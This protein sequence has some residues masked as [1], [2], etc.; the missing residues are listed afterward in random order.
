M[1]ILNDEVY[2]GERKFKLTIRDPIN[3]EIG[4]GS[5]QATILDDEPQPLI[6]HFT[7]MPS[8]NHGETSFTFNISFN[9]D[10]A[11]QYLVMQNDA[12]TVTNGEITRA[13]RIDGSRDFWRITVQP[14]GGADVTVLLPATVSCSDT[15][16]ICT[17]DSHA[18]PLSN[19]VTHTFPGTQ[20][21]AKFTGLD[22]YHDGSTPF[23]FTLG[24][25]EEVDTTA[26][27][28]RDHAL[29]ITGGT[30]KTV[31]QKD[32][33]STRRWEV[34]VKPAGVDDI[35]VSI[36]GAIDCATDGHI[37]TSE[38]ELL[39]QAVTQYS[40]GPELISVS[41]ATVREADG[42]ELVFT[43]SIPEVWFG[44]DIT[45]DYATSHGTATA[46]DYTPTSGTLD[47]RWH[48]SLIVTVPV[49]TDTIT[50][51]A[52][53]ITLTLSN[54]VNVVIADGEATGTIQDAEPVA[55]RPPDSQPTGLP[56]ITGA[57]RA[58]EPL[59][60][61]TSAIID[62]NGL[63]EVS[64][65]Y[66][67]I[68]ST[69]GS[70]ADL[71]GATASTY[72]PNNDQVGNTFKVR[73]S[74]TDDDDYAHTLT[75]EATI[76]LTQPTD[77][78]V[79]SAD[80][81]VVEYS[82]ISIGAASADLFTNIGGTR[83]LSI[84]SLWSYVPDQDLRLA[85]N[86][87]LDDA[88]DL[89]LIVGELQLEFP[90]NSSG[91]GSFKWTAV[92]VDWQDGQTITVRIVPTSSLQETPT[93]NTAAAGQPTITGTPQVGQVLTADTSQV[94]DADGLLTVSYLYQWIAD[95]VDITNA[96]GP[97][98]TLSSA[99]QGKPVKVKVSFNDD[100]NNPETLT[101]IAT[102]PVAARPNT[103]ANGA[104]S[105]QGVLQDQGRL[106]ADI[107]GII[108][109][110]GLTSAT[111]AYQ[112]MRVDDGSPSDIAGQTGSTYSLT[113]SD[114]GQRV[115]LQVTF[116][117]DRGFSESLTSAVT[118]RVTDSSSTRKLLWL[119][120]IV[121]NDQDSQITDYTYD[122]S[123]DAPV[124]SPAAF[125]AD[126]DSVQTITYL[127]ASP[128]DAT[129]FAID[130]S[131]Q[132]TNQQTSTWSLQILG[133]ELDFRNATYAT[134]STSPPAHRYQWDVTEYATDTASLPHDGD[135]LT[136]SIQEAINL[137]ATG[138]PTI[139]GTPEVGQTLTADTSA[140][141]DGNG[142]SNVSYEYQWTAGGTNIDGATNSSLT[143]TSSQE[144][145]TIQ[146]IVTFDDDDGFSEIATS[147]AT[148]A[149]AVGTVVNSQPN[150][151]PTISGT[152]QVDET[153]TASTAAI[154]D[155]DGLANVSY[156]YQWLRDDADIAG[157]T[158]STYELVS[159]DEGK[160][161]KVRVTF[162]DDAGNAESL[163]STATTPVAAQPAETPAVLLTASFANVPAD[164]NGSN[165]TFQLIFSEN[166]EAGYARIRDHA[167]TVTGAT[168][169][170]ASRITQGSNQGWNVEVNPTG[171]EAITITLPE[172]TNC[173][174]DE[175]ICTDD[176]RMLSH[177]TEER[178]EGPPAISVSDAT[179]QEAEGATLEFSVTLSHASSR[180]V[181]V[182]Y[183]TQDGTATAGPD[184]TATSATLTFNAGDLSQTVE[185][186]VLTDSEDEGQE[187]L[188]L[189]LYNPSQATLDD[190]TG[191]GTI[192]NGESS[193]G[194]QEDPPAE[195][196]A[197]LLTASFDNMPATHNGSE[198]TF[199]LA[200]S[201]DFPLSYVTLRDDAFTVDGGNV[202]NAQ[203]KVPGSNQT[204][205]ITV[206]PLGAGTISI[207]LP[208]TTDCN[209]TGAICT[210][211][212]R[213]LSHTNVATITGPG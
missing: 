202:E 151:L 124:L 47:F 39:A 193:S 22:D 192:E 60:A 12:M 8:G 113:S 49:L 133:V 31:V 19:S 123:T 208:E 159:A 14:D 32:D 51:D 104:P 23:N 210:D 82:S 142:I 205:T 169:D 93:P 5:G 181:T 78:I 18:T 17:R 92:D 171:N 206:K 70:D 187:T 135:P 67:W 136:V 97:T 62:A 168:I 41:D 83:S 9:Q 58:D 57:F 44:P 204:W 178:V 2:T 173:S 48:K 77:T 102:E 42:A 150:G 174:N 15:G 11:T 96:T 183:A 108:D 134:T 24:F 72:T 33:D 106:T 26:A 114:V 126:Q 127:G 38:G 139:G 175:A 121:P 103:P 176:E 16:A 89:S 46:D 56:V 191:T 160:T 203:R 198:F 101:S 163:T 201:E 154:S 55:A 98:Y 125:T 109:A 212:D 79:W 54:P 40:T 73:V 68:M 66:Q 71:S 122:G 128:G 76:P 43:V 153:L 63:D 164:H 172:T 137:S 53:T 149:V 158:N 80:M 21:N 177:S 35:E 100:R 111:F 61:D 143:L 141:T 64:Y 115:Q 138:Q 180:T 189:T 132:L 1:P 65:S 140:I 162:N 10:V 120:T 166:V 156:Q 195:T 147:E 200:F 7:N 116:T 197:V 99:D 213:K 69:N 207:T 209:A 28:I 84:Q 131:F 4:D 170:S 87:A 145:D 167:F 188:T 144:G 185:V 50:E 190:G 74:F 13:E 129:E 117:D 112:W 59:T 119:A 152:P 194:T 36:A 81:L 52:E 155:E 30:F 94:T 179:V 75:S 45:V 6:A 161:I 211:D 130:L 118:S 29:T 90:P 157:Q 182:S 186:T 85:F 3:A 95:D 88:D 20:L 110:D 105:M 91:N 199:D 34:T 86:E 107:A 146:V 27:E 165:F 184:Y 37:C 196:P 25:S 148:T